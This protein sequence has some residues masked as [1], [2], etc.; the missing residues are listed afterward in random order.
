MENDDKDVTLSYDVREFLET[1]GEALSQYLERLHKNKNRGIRRTMR[2]LCRLERARHLYV[3]GDM[4]WDGYTKIKYETNGLLASAYIPEFDDAVEA[5]KILSD[6][7]D[8]WQCASVG[9]RN[10]MLRTMLHA[11]YVDPER[12]QLIGLAPKDAFYAPVLAMAEGDD[13]AVV[14]TEVSV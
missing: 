6:F 9:Q 4:P 1:V 14:A 11:V 12:K 7:R 8:L 13:V 2:L 10:R 3:V 5:G